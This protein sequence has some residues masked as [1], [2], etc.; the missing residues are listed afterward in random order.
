MIYKV[1]YELEVIEGES[2]E[3]LI[4]YLSLSYPAGEYEI[5]QVNEVGEEILYATYTKTPIYEGVA[6][7]EQVLLTLRNGSI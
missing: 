2:F 5:Y 4:A 7:K 3:D 6:Y 1:T